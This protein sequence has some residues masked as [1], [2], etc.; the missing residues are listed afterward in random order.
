[1]FKRYLTI[2]FCFTILCFCTGCLGTLEDTVLEGADMWRTGM[3]ENVLAAYRAPE[4]I[5]KT[6]KW[7]GPNAKYALSIIKGKLVLLELAD[8]GPGVA[9]SNHW[10][11]KK[12]NDHFLT[13]VWKNSAWHYIIAPDRVNAVR[14]VYK[15]GKYKVDKSEG[16][17]KVIGKPFAL[18]K[19]ERVLIR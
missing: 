12:G 3:P 10:V 15:Y 8:N 1:M 6:K 18:C 14:L 7:I 4:C 11:D 9:I 17:I 13:Y 2:I 19:M 5:G 16:F